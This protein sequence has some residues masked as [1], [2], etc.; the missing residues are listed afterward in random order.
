LEDPSLCRCHRSEGTH[1]H[2]HCIAFTQAQ[3]LG[4]SAATHD[5]QQNSSATEAFNT[6]DPKEVLKKDNRLRKTQRSILKRVATAAFH[7]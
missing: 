6:I 1:T 2:T 3:E 4:R 5:C 7:A